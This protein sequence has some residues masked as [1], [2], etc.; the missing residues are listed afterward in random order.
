M[1]LDVRSFLGCAYRCALRVAGGL[2]FAWDDGP[3]CPGA[4]RSAGALRG[5]R[6]YFFLLVPNGASHHHHHHHRK[7]WKDRSSLSEER[8][9]RW[10]WKCSSSCQRALRR[11]TALLGDAIDFYHRRGQG[12]RPIFASELLILHRRHAGGHLDP[13]GPQLPLAADGAA[14]PPLRLGK[15]HSAETGALG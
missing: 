14:E 11:R 6:H 8:W 5:R 2:L 13:L 4:M 7:H 9:W 15:C 12:Q 10:W 3:G 1:T